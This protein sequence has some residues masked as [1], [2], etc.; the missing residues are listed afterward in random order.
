LQYTV[1]IGMHIVVPESQDMKILPLKPRIASGIS[2][3][4]MLTTIHF[5]NEPGLQTS[6]IRDVGANRHLASE[7]N[8][9]ESVRAQSV[10]KLALGIRHVRAKRPGV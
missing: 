2:L 1:E 9:I 5:H 3:R 6:K 10:P 4:S 8:P 7:R